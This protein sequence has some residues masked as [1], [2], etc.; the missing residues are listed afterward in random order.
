MRPPH[1]VAIVGGGPAG[2]VAAI[3]LA[4]AG[5]RVRLFERAIFPRR[6]LCGDSLNPG[7]RALLQRL[8][9]A[10]RIE[11]DAL[12]VEGMIVS[13]AGVTVRGSYAAGTRGLSLTRAVLDAHLLE[14]AAAAGVE[15][16][17]GVLVQEATC[18]LGRH[19]I[20]VTG[21]RVRTPGG[22]TD[23]VPARMCIAA[24]GRHSRIGFGLRLSRHPARPRR[25]ATGRYFSDVEGVGRFGEMHIRDGHYIGVA[26]VP[27]TLVNVCLITADPALLQDPAES[28]QRVLASDA[29]L[30][31]RFAHAR[32][33]GPAVTL[34]PLAVQAGAAGMPG[35]LLAGDA[36]GFIDPMT[37]D[38]LR[39]ALRGAELAAEAAVHALATGDPRAH[40]RLASRRAELGRKRAFNRTLRALVDSPRAVRLAAAGA[41]LAPGV[42]RR[43]ID[44]AGDVAEA[45]AA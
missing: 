2:S 1:D 31:D 32:P 16:E 41:R 8:K 28:L 20:T 26:A 44:I 22:A 24:D 37:G 23:D 29:L 45:R 6:K 12:E 39:F 19:G 9:L 5:A 21:L 25:W 27:G 18:A 3:L 11:R 34:G 4:R 33:A 7:A 43:I 38:G 42:L 15:V 35:L 13:G 10:D 40:E 30:R 17:H 14:A 36:A